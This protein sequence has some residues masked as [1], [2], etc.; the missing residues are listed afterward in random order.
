MLSKVWAMDASTRSQ[1]QRRE[2]K[3][4]KR[5]K[6]PT[7]KSLK[8]GATILHSESRRRK[9]GARSRHGRDADAVLSKLL[10]EDAEHVLSVGRLC[11][12]LKELLQARDRDESHKVHRVGP[13]HVRAVRGVLAI[14][15]KHGFAGALHLGSGRV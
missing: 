13:I 11:L 4:R 3:A 15:Q 8:A 6:N 14:R 9:R 2:Q 7:K 10:A 5:K 1:A 12:G